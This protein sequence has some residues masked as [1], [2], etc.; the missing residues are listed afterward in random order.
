MTPTLPTHSTS[1]FNDIGTPVCFLTGQAGTGKSYLIKQ[2]LLEDPTFGL[3]L[4]TTG[5]AAINLGTVTVNS[6]L[7]F[8]NSESLRDA[9]YD[10][11]LQKRLLFHKAKGYQW[12][13]IDEG[14]MLGKEVF[15][16]IY[17]GL[18]EVNASES[19]RMP[20][21][22]MIIGDMAQLP[23]VPDEKVINGAPV[24]GKNGR[25]EKWPIPWA[26]DADCWEK[27]EAATIKLDKIWRQDN[28]RFLGALNAIRRGQGGS[29]AIQLQQ[30]GVK[31][32]TELPKTFDGTVIVGTNA[33]ADAINRK[34]LNE[35]NGQPFTV[36]S[37][38]WYSRKFQPSEWKYVEEIQPL[39]IGALVMILAN[40]YPN[41]TYANGD[42]GHIVGFSSPTFSDPD[43][44]ESELL[45]LST[46]PMIEVELLR[47]GA[48]VFIPKIK[49]HLWQQAEP[50]D[51]YVYQNKDKIIQ[52]R[53]PGVRRKVWITGELDYYP[54]RLAYATTVHKCQGLTLESAAVD[55]RGW[56]FKKPA[57]VYVALSR[58]KS[59]EGLLI[60]GTPG[61][62]AKKVTVDP[63]VM[64]FL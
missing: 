59:P 36:T 32:V 56:F 63:K 11:H 39:K 46:E 40:D 60:V 34:R 22:L 26:F 45:Q 37:E 52:G 4:A 25:V 18:D 27:F 9:Y 57:M 53:V 41:F 19:D 54:I 62:L 58:V 13:L 28:E 47:N 21:G 7:G 2:M 1:T 24:V 17:L 20:L 51:A 50:E 38:R 6:A 16:Y 61:D 64:R 30:A 35:I 33:E 12:L 55:I 10:G 5:I 15:D 43:E 48:H 31:F 14:S 49:R 8:A 23:P 3:P 29:G 42:L 44:T